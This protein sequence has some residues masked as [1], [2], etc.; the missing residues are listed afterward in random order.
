MSERASNAVQ[1][2]IVDARSESL[3]EEKTL[4]PSTTSVSYSAHLP[5]DGRADG[6]AAKANARSLGNNKKSNHIS[7]ITI[8][9]Y[10]LL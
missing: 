1:T 6:V 9:L 10:A 3:S 5:I 2:G 7:C 8:I 4:C